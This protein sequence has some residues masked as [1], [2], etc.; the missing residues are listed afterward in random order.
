MHCGYI[1]SWN[2]TMEYRLPGE[3]IVYAGYVGNQT[4]RQFLDRD[5]NAAPWS[6]PR[7]AS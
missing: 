5:I 2:Y 3:T 6:A 7:T 4:V 1:H